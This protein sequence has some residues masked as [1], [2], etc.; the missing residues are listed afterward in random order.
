MVSYS[1]G[2]WATGQGKFFEI[3]QKMDAYFGV[4]VDNRACIPDNSW[5]YGPLCPTQFPSVKASEF[6]EWSGKI[7]ENIWENENLKAL[8]TLIGSTFLTSDK[9][10]KFFRSRLQR[11]RLQPMTCFTRRF[12]DYSSW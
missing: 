2:I 9:K 3:V 11:S 5:H 4:R 1:Q 12:C 8:D 7:L 10:R 6:I